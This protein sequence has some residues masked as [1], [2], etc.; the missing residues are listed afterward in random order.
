MLLRETIKK[1]ALG[2]GKYNYVSL[3]LFHLFY[4]EGQLTEGELTMYDKQLLKLKFG[5]M[6]EPREDTPEPEGPPRGAPEEL[7]RKVAREPLSREIKEGQTFLVLEKEISKIRKIFKNQVRILGA[8]AEIF[9]GQPSIEDYPDLLRKALREGNPEEIANLKSEVEE[10]KARERELKL[11]IWRGKTEIREANQKTNEQALL[12]RDVRQ[13]FEVDP[14]MVAKAK[15][16]DLS[17]SASGSMQPA[18]V[19]G[20]M[21][22][23]AKRVRD[24]QRNLSLISGN[25][26]REL[27]QLPSTTSTTT[28]RGINLA[29]PSP[30]GRQEPPVLKPEVTRKSGFRRL[31]KLSR[32]QPELEE[33][34]VVDLESEDDEPAPLRAQTTFSPGLRKGAQIPDPKR[35]VSESSE[36][37][38]SSESSEEEE[39]MSE[40]EDS[41]S[42][43]PSDVKEVPDPKVRNEEDPHK[44]LFPEIV[45]KLAADPEKSNPEKG[46]REMSVPEAEFQGREFGASTP[47]TTEVERIIADATFALRTPESKAP[48]PVSP[49][50][51]ATIPGGT[52]P[53]PGDGQALIELSHLEKDARKAAKKAKKKAK[54]AKARAEVGAAGAGGGT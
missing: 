38:E 33:T 16:M 10:G 22:K 35:E 52:L 46:D 23:F 34:K 28:F 43:K 54:K 50:G 29:S 48:N 41:E 17:A 40:D 12:V 15:L 53:L 19:I 14:E 11:Q 3:Y 26:I 8:M 51:L 1:Q 20:M 2:I 39:S 31:T 7:K 32:N 37:E 6:D 30:A 21:A 27:E 18:Q 13:F 44:S 25:V 36:S 49:S 9:P 45:K 4:S 42:P 5:A 47:T 24:A